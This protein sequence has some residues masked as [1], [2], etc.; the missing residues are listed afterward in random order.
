L[1]GYIHKGKLLLDLRTVDPD[2]DEALVA[3]TRRALQAR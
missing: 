1:I 2:D 3:A